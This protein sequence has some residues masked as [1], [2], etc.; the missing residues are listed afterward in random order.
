MMN[1]TTFASKE[2]NEHLKVLDNKARFNGE[3]I[4]S[5]LGNTPNC[6]HYIITGNEG[7]GQSEAVDEIYQ[8]IGRVTG[9]EEYVVSDAALMF[10]SSAGF[11]NSLRN[12]CKE[13]ILLHI[14]NAD[15][16]SMRGYANPKDGMEALYDMIPGMTNSI[17]VLSGKRNVLL[18]LVNGHERAKAL[19]TYM[20]HFDDLTP[21]ALFQFMMD[22][23]N[24]QNYQFDPSAEPALKDYLTISY[25]QRG[26]NFR[27]KYFVQDIFERLIVPKMSERVMKAYVP[28]LA[29]DLCTIMPEDLPVMEQPNSE[30]AINKLKSLV[31]LESI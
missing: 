5:G 23:A 15:Q 24:S 29:I 30:D 9:L 17:V 31:G 13:N 25:R 22:Y 21:D 19:F 2:F 1:L 7:V 26:A 14:R 4:A 12:I 11:E 16:L 6:Q 18:E 3:R 28:G 20:F 27:N 10:D 8:R